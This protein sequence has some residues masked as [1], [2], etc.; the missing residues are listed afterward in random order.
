MTTANH[1]CITPISYGTAVG[2]VIA[3]FMIWC[4]NYMGK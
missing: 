2:L 1:G 4:S 3:V